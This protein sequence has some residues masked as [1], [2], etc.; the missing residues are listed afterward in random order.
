LRVTI[1][2]IDLQ[3]LRQGDKFFK[4]LGET[5][6]KFNWVVKIIELDLQPL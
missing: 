4:T 5:N 3:P 2:G 1:K 6:K